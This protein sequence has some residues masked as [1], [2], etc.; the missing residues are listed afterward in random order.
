MPLILSAFDRFLA[1]SPRSFVVLALLSA[2]ASACGD[3]DGSSDDAGLVDAAPIEGGMDA[4][5]LDGGEVDGGLDGGL[6]A[7][8]VACRPMPAAN[9]TRYVV[10]A[11][12]FASD[13]NRYTLHTLS[14]VG[15]LVDA[16]RSFVMGRGYDGEIAFSRDGAFGVVAQ[17]D[18]SLGIFVLGDDGVP[19]VR[20]AQ[21]MGE[22]Y[23]ARVIADPNDATVFWILDSQTRTNGGGIYRLELDCEGRVVSEALALAAELPYGLVFEADGSALIAAKAIGE[24]ARGEDDIFRVDLA[25]GEVESRADVL[26]GDDWIGA[27]I[28]LGP[29]HVV[30]ADNAAFSEVSNR[31]GVART[32][33]PLAPAPEVTDVEDAV[34]LVFSPFGDQLLA[35]SG[36][37]D[38]LFT[39]SYDADASPPLG[40]P[41]ALTYTGGRPQL[42][43]S[44]VMLRHGT[45][46]GLVLIAENQAIRRVRF[47]EGAVVDLGATPLGEGSDAIPGAI[48][49]Q[50]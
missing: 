31:L 39:L 48:G 19:E 37:G 38:A 8:P 44:T 10:V 47:E 29:S 25:T 6:D 40:A 36:F 24:E 42:P 2:L 32:G 16:E 21:R 49:V 9:R 11:R 22:A 45:L 26:D 17:N 12:P 20:V 34:A 3:D 1:S 28:A 14:E 35:V 33:R 18:G 4:S 46:E 15:E 41:A 27:G 23:A 50:P 43:S 13:P 7:G 5:A 30:F